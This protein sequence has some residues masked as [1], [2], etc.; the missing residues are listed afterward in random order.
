MEIFMGSVNP[1]FI[2]VDKLTDQWS[3]RPIGPDD[4]AQ[5]DAPFG[6]YT[7]TQRAQ[8]ARVSSQF[9]YPRLAVLDLSNNGI[10]V[11]GLIAIAD[12]IMVRFIAMRHTL[13]A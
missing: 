5:S 1:E 11:S 9:V 6:R 7:D 12:L 8:L 2:D 13:D 4:V 3:G 10:G